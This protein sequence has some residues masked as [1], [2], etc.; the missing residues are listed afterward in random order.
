M[1]A[2]CTGNKSRFKRGF[3]A[4]VFVIAGLV[5]W[6][7][8]NLFYSA[9]WVVAAGMGLPV[10]ETQMTAYIAAHLFPFLLTC[11]AGVGFYYFIRSHI[12]DQKSAASQPPIEG[13]SNDSAPT[14]KA[15]KTPA[16]RGLKFE[17]GK[18]SEPPLTEEEL[19]SLDPFT[20]ALNVSDISF[21]KENLESTSLIHITVCVF[22]GTGHPIFL[23]SI[24]GFA[25]VSLKYNNQVEET[26]LVERLIKPHFFNATQNAFD[27]YG[28]FYFILEQPLPKEVV[29][30][31]ENW[32]SNATFIFNFENLTIT[33]QS[34]KDSQ[35]NAAI[36]LWDMAV[37]HR[38]GGGI[39]AMAGYKLRFDRRAQL[40]TGQ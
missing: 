23:K 4:F 36:P 32:P 38:Q 7:S 31:I 15:F 3:I 22:N 18:F 5:A 1:T 37:L 16:F 12:G 6:F 2:V 26:V 25:S 9:F 35:K 30:Q 39:K 28:P 10:T 20:S 14:P 17:N 34:T 19:A 13:L 24:D 27:G 21:Q 40:P 11:A 33:V 29:T 8:S